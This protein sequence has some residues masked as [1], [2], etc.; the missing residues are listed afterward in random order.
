MRIL[1]LQNKTDFTHQETRFRCSF[2]GFIHQY[3][4]RLVTTY[5]FQK[6]TKAKD[7]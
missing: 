4:Y 3:F 6:E 5:C 1:N 7:T 2:G